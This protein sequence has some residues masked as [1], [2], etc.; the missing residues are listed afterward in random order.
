M[1]SKTN[2]EKGTALSAIRVRMSMHLESLE[3]AMSLGSEQ[4]G[5]KHETPSLRSMLQSS[6]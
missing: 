2:T 3:E 5:N 1:H 6:G 4:F